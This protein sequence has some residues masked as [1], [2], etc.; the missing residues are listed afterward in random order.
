MVYVHD[1][2]DC[3]GTGTTAFQANGGR[4]YTCCGRKKVSPYDINREAARKGKR[5][6]LSSGRK[7]G[8]LLLVDVGDH[9]EWCEPSEAA[10]LEL[11]VLVPTEDGWG[12]EVNQIAAVDGMTL[13]AICEGPPF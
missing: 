7:V 12:W 6:T 13:E 2:P 1:C 5:I 11:D 9:L 10:R 3:R 8:D 4:C